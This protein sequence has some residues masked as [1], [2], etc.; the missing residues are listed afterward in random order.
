[1][2]VLEEQSV[3]FGWRWGK[4]GAHQLG[5]NCGQDGREVGGALGTGPILPQI[6]CHVKCLKDIALP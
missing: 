2:P 1:M 6:F 3:L 5:A 4:G